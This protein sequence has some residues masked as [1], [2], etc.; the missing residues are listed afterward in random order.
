MNKMP[1]SMTTDLIFCITNLIV[2]FIYVFNG[3][4]TSSRY[5]TIGAFFWLTMFK[6]DDI[7]TRLP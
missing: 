2:S 6:I 3:N 7:K 4:I 5:F 1:V